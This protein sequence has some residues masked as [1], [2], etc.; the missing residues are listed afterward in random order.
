MVVVRTLRGA[1]VALVTA[2]VPPGTY[3][4]LELDVHAVETS[5][6]VAFD[7]LVERGASVL[8]E[9]SVDGKPFTF[10]SGLEIELEQE[11][12]FQLGAAAANITLD[13]DAAT[14]FRAADGS[15]LNP[16]DPAAREAILANIRASFRAFEDD[17]QDGIE[18]ER[19]HRDAG[20]DHGDGGSDD[21]SGH[22]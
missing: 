12:Q 10:A 18:D 4:K 19:E 5:P 16:L 6:S 17:D 11:G 20:D 2:H 8:V 13:L 1:L 9:G 7:D 21:G 15:R 14:W 3:D 22:H